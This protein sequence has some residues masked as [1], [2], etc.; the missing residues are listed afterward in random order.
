MPYTYPSDDDLA[1][2]GVTG[3]FL[4][5]Y[6]PWDGLQN[7][8]FAQSHGFETWPGTIEGSLC[9]YENLDNHQ[10]GIH[11]YFKFIK[12]GFG[13]ATDIASMHVRRDRLRRADALELVKIHDGAFPWTYLG[14]PIE[15]LL[16]N[17]DMSFD[18]FIGGVRPLHQQAAVRD[19]PARRA[20][21]RRPHGADEDQL[22]TT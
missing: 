15:E 17:I 16:A 18:E 22:T 20:R 1:R 4:G 11:D 14:K 12:Y 13:R 10:T 19:R 7:A 3:I 5:Y 8:I 6:M 2:V 21:A 9:N